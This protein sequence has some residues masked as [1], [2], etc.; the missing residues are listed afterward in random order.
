MA[1]TT[2][3][4]SG[5]RVS[6]SRGWNKPG[7]EST[8]LRPGLQRSSL[9]QRSQSDG[10]APASPERRPRPA[11]QRSRSATSDALVRPR[12]SLL[13]TTR[14]PLRRARSLLVE[15]EDD[16]TSHAHT[17]H[18]PKTSVTVDAA[19]DAR[20]AVAR[21]GGFL[22]AS[23]LLSCAFFGALE[24]WT[25]GEALYFSVVTLTTVGYGDLAP[26]TK[27]ERLFAVVLFFLGAGVVGAL[28]AAAFE[29]LIATAKLDAADAKRA[30]AEGVDR[31]RAAPRERLRRAVLQVF[32]WAVGGA[33]TFVVLEHADWVDAL[34]WS[35]A[36][37]TT[38]GYGDVVPE[39]A[40]GRAFA[41]VFCL[42]GTLVC[43]HALSTIAAAPLEAHRLEM[44]AR[45]LGQYGD[46]LSH[47]EFLELTR[48]E[49]I[50]SLNVDA[51]DGKCTKATFALAMLVKLGRIDAADVA[52][53]ASQFDRLDHNASGFLAR[54]D[55]ESPH[56]T[57]SQKLFA[58]WTAGGLD[59]DDDDGGGGGGDAGGVALLPLEADAGDASPRAARA[60][61]AA[62]SRFRRAGTAV[63]VANR[64]R[65]SATAKV[66][67]GIRAK[68]R[69]SL[70]TPERR[71][72]AGGDV[73]SPMADLDA[74][75]GL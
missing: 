34:Y 68:R 70:T 65:A 20:A 75:L 23:L 15:V 25:V 51:D 21:G 61:S 44:E 16:T 2:A 59:D 12:D 62:L 14:P 57:A 48:G 13:S 42:G 45:V 69:A 17:V 64:L 71:D 52:A 9:Y 10:A 60:P 41:A 31:A 43:V 4:A 37:L 50:R 28:T 8:P 19:G 47:E 35:G 24:R 11:F 3:R 66:A 53:C 38:V 27:G 40:A 32:L 67:K 18:A 26:S 72:D 33:G 22:A 55:V 73:E 1:D 5:P 36:T 74:Y 6:F 7:D 29:V 58:A 49:L 46:T 39:T 54:E 56:P 30:A 63:K